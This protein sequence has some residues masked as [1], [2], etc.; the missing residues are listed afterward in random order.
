M[1]KVNVMEPSKQAWPQP[2][3][4]NFIELLA[5]LRRDIA[6]FER[7][8]EGETYR[9]CCARVRVDDSLIH[10]IRGLGEIQSE[11]LYDNVLSDEI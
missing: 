1:L 2:Q 10:A 11:Y 8:T 3:I 5:Q 9:E 6:A 4:Q 7:S